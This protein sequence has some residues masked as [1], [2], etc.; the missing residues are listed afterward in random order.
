M[1]IPI[2]LAML[3]AL[4]SSPPAPCQCL[5]MDGSYRTLCTSLEDARAGIDA[6]VGALPGQCPTSLNAP[7]ASY[8]SPGAGAANCRDAQVFDRASGEHIMVKVCDAL[9]AP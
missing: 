7:A 4:S 5:C 3:G 6:C 9:P 1:G 8:P 2:L